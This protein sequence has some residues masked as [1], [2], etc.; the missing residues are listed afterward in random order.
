MSL[1]PKLTRQITTMTVVSRESALPGPAPLEMSLYWVARAAHQC[2][3]KTALA[4]TTEH[5]AI[6]HIDVVHA[7]RN[8]KNSVSATVLADTAMMAAPMTLAMA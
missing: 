7:A 8:T 3:E 4:S 2:M 1:V 5:P 6:L